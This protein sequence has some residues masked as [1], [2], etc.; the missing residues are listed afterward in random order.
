MGNI[1]INLKQII[2]LFLI[3]SFLGCNQSIPSDDLN[4]IENEESTFNESSFYGAWKYEDLK[5]GTIFIQFEM[6]GTVKAFISYEGEYLGTGKW[7]LNG[8]VLKII[9]CYPLVDMVVN[10]FD[11][12]SFKTK[13]SFDESII[14][15]RLKD[16]AGEPILYYSLFDREPKQDPRYGDSEIS[17]TEDESSYGSSENTSIQ[18]QWV[19]CRYCHGSGTIICSSCKGSR[20]TECSRCNGAGYSGD[21][22]CNKCNGRGI[23]TC[24]RCNGAGYSGDCQKCSGRGQVQE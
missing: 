6:D 13:N 8:K 3:V 16:E 7:E 20:Q 14:F 5:F 10:N 17:T 15:N 19:N 23:R 21:Y 22:S 18:K 2:F 9:D 1:F 12:D 24:K 11:G 4:P